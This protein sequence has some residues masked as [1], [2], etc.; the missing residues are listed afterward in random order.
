M[1]GSLM[2]MFRQNSLWLNTEGVHSI[3]SFFFSRSLASRLSI[4]NE[5][6]QAI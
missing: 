6:I 1:S 2:G 4:R 3:L 5:E